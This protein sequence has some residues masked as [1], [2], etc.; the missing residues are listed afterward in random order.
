MPYII[1]GHNLIGKTQG[2]DLED[3]EDEKILIDLLQDF[4]QKKGKRAEVYFDKGAMGHASARVLGRVTVRFV[5]DGET[6]DNAI[7]RKL[8]S[9][10]KEAANWT[11]VSSDNE[12]KAAGKR[13]HTKVIS[14][15]DFAHQLLNREVRNTERDDEPL[16]SGEV[17]EWLDL[18]ENSDKED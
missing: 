2:L 13:A 16:S 3:P 10:G 5:R 8:K 18:F 17:E 6:A 1:D 14:S 4:C 12:V 7:S 9:L 15:V 11:M